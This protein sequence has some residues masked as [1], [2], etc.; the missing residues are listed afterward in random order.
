MGAGTSG[1]SGL[2]GGCMFWFFS[3]RG[4]WEQAGLGRILVLVA[5][6]GFGGAKLGVHDVSRI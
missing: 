3:R 1:G 6:A 2:W 5:W 4:I